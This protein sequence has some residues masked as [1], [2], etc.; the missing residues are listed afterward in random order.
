MPKRHDDGRTALLFTLLFVAGCQ[1][2]APKTT[3]DIGGN[4]LAPPQQ[5]GQVAEHPQDPMRE[6]VHLGE[7]VHGKPID[8]AVLREMAPHA[9]GHER[10]AATLPWQHLMVFRKPS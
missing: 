1:S 2:A 10:T 9:L 3:I 6:D 5:R 4:A 7:S 8:M